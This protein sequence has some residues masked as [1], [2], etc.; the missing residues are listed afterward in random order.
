MRVFPLKDKKGTKIT[1]TFQTLFD[2]SSHK[3]NKIYVVKSSKFYNRS[4][5]SWL[6]DNGMEMYSTHN[7]E[8][9]VVAKRI[10]GTLKNSIHK[11]MISV[12]KNVYIDK[13]NDIVNKCNNMS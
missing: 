11:Y 8:K 6:Q 12:P 1:N 4:L 10:I 2:E 7:E 13:L 3:H 9:Y 5:K